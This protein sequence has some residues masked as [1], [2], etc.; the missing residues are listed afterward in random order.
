VNLPRRDKMA[1][2]RYQEIPAA[3]IPEVIA[4]DGA[5]RVR[6]IAGESLGARAVIET[7]TPIL[8]LHV[9]LEPGARFE[10]PLPEGFN[11][12]AYVVRG[13]GRFGDA[14][15]AASRRPLVHFDS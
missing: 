1:E 10:Q 14:G 4:E 7:H 12:F 15:Q 9:R 6:V 11:G 13:D 5:V 8:Y 2:P 3:R